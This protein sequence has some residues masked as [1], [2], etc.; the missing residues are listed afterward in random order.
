MMAD[1]MPPTT[2]RY[3]LVFSCIGHAFMHLFAVYFFLVVLPLER[4]WA[5][6]YHELIELWTIGS[7]LVGAMALPAGWLGDRWS[8]PGMLVVFFLGLGG[9]AILC[10]LATTPTTMW[11]GLCL[12][13]VFAAIYHPVGVAWLVRS[14]TASRGKALGINGIFGSGGVAGAGLVAGTLIDLYG[15]RTAFFVPGALSVATG[16]GMLYCLV[17]GRL[18]DRPAVHAATPAGAHT[19]QMRAFVL[20]LVTMFGGAIIYQATQTAMPKVFALRLADVGGG[21]TLGVGAFVALVYGC[22]GLT[23][24]VSGHFA[25][26]FDLKTVY[27]GT[28]LIQVPV[29]WVAASAGGFSLVAASAVL[30][31]ANSGSLPAENMLLAAATPER[32]HGVAFG[33]KFVVAFGAAPVAIRLVAYINDVTGEFTNLFLFLAAVG[34]GVV[35]ASALLPKL[36][37]PGALA[38]GPPDPNALTERAPTR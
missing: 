34:L 18:I 27:I 32:R 22:A 37:R 26:R 30:V 8:A 20:L 7:L 2:A 13:G 23:Q 19:G 9:A 25:D 3:A 35:A 21:S 38:P 33:I 24:I 14:T 36:Q 11:T 10:G 5:M 31:M 28:F 15:W 29:L 16:G 1:A 4:E 6:P 17:S 12:L